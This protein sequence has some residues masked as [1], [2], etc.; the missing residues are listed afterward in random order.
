MMHGREKSDSAIVAGKPTGEDR[1]GTPRVPAIQEEHQARG[2]ENPCADRPIGD[3]AR[4]HKAGGK[5]EPH[6][7]RMDELLSGRN[8][9][10]SV[11]GARQLRGMRL[12][13]WLRF[14]H[15]VRRS[16][17]GAYPLSH[18]YE[19][20]GLIRLTRLWRDEPWAKA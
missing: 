1:P 12:R 2:R 7:T 18:L 20:F 13:R 6:A 16:K 5:V 9:Q 8:R 14:K 17:G 10:Q 11:S 15:K 4:D 3:M 19:H